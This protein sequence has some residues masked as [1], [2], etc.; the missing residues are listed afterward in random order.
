MFVSWGG[1]CD[2]HATEVGEAK[3]RAM[4]P[5][6]VEDEKAMR[7]IEALREQIERSYQRQGEALTSDRMLELSQRL[8]KLITEYLRRQI[9]SRKAAAA[10]F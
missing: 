1:H 6:S 3:P 9:Q 2:N 7:Q 5:N 8:D 10:G 4:D